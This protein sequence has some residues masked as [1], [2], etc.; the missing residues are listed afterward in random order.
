MTMKIAYMFPGQGSQF[1]G[2][3]EGL[4]GQF[5]AEC[6]VAEEVLGYSLE[7]LCQDPRS[8]RLNQTQYTQPA[9]YF[10]SCLW[11][12]ERSRRAPP[13]DL[14]L[15]HSLGLYAAMFAGGMMSLRTGLEVVKRRA[16]LMQAATGGAMLA[17]IGQEAGAAQNF[18]LEHEYADI[19]VANYNAPDQI[20]FSGAAETIS[21]LELRLNGEQ[22]RCIRLPV[23]GAFHSR[24]MEA[25]RLEFTRGLLLREFNPPV[26]PVVSTTSATPVSLEFI[27]EELGF[28][29]V[30]PVRWHQTVRYL[31]ETY[32][33]LKFTEIGPGQVTS[34]LT[35]RIVGADR[36]SA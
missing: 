5:P 24:L 15:G 23:S 18:L 36:I 33:D 35:T 13:P 31:A 27:V 16:E 19:D 4:F 26:I 20:V 14:L 6:A 9:V 34:K 21:A 12:L 11:Y 7:E 22:F 3:G 29:L 28:Q 1:A 25:A 32:A 10:V 17:V 8:N 2:M 30:R